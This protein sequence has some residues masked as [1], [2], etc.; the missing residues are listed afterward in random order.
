[1]AV[2]MFLLLDGIDGES[3]DK[4]YTGQIDV[5]AWGWGVSNFGTGHMGG[6]SGAGKADF[7]DI[8]VTKYVD[9]ASATLLQFCATGKHIKEGVL[10]VRK[11]GGEQQE[12]IEMEMEQILVTSVTTGGSGGEDRLTENIS[13][14]FAAFKYKYSPQTKTGDAAK[15]PEFKYNIAERAAE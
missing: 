12:Y 14:N 2:D 15:A 11:A 6:G 10:I 9:K 7:Q 4:T 1:M 13:L 8:S 3:L 5:L